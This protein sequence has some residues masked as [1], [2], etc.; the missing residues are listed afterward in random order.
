MIRKKLKTPGTLFCIYLILN[1]L[2]RFFIETIRITDKYTI[3]GYNLTQAQIIGL[4]IVLIGLII[5]IYLNRAHES[6]KE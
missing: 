6:I 1:G 5:A 4:L 2:E 3:L